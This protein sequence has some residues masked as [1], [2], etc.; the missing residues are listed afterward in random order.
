MEEVQEWV[1]GGVGWVEVNRGVGG[2][3]EEWGGWRSGVGGGVGWAVEWGGR[4]SGVGSG[5]GWAVG[6]AVE[7]GG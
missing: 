1:S 5:V 3:V 2:G 7:R 4:W 6:W